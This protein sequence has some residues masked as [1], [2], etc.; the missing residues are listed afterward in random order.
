[1]FI[2]KLLSLTVFTLFS[3]S[4]FADQ[5]PKISQA[6]LI[7]LLAQPNNSD[8]FVLDVRTPKEYNNGHIEGAIN[9]S[10]NTIT[11][12]FSFLDS[13]KNKMIVV[14]CQS[15]RRAVSAENALKENGFHN[16]RHLEGDMLGW[17]AAKLPVIKKSQ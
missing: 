8:F 2:K 1:M 7:T 17:V 14:H 10:H 4:V 6:E 15:G 16:I 3:L 5:T 11:K 13:Y 9:I 12:N